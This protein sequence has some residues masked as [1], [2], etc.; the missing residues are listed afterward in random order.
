MLFRSAKTAQQLLELH[1]DFTALGEIADGM[2]ERSQWSEVLE[3]Y[4]S[5]F[6]TLV[7]QNSVTKLVGGLRKLLAAQTSDVSALELLHKVYQEAGNAGDSRDITENLA[8]VYRQSG[9]LDK[10]RELYKQLAAIEPD[11][12]D[13]VQLL[14]R[15]ESQMGLETSPDQAAA[16]PAAA[17]MSE[18][19]DFPAGDEPAPPEP[20]ALSAHEEQIVKDCITEAELYITYRQFDRALK[21]IEAGLVQ[22]PGN[23]ALTEQLLSIC[24]ASSLYARA[25][26]CCE[27]LTEAYVRLGDGERASRYGERLLGYQ[28]KSQESAAGAPQAP[29]ADESQ[30]SLR[31]VGQTEAAA[32]DYSSAT[33]EMAA[34]EQPGDQAQVREVDL[35]MEWASAATTPAATADDSL[36][37]EIEFYLQASLLPDAAAALQRLKE[38]S[39]ANPAI[40]GFEE[41]LGLNAT[42]GA[43]TP[44]P[45]AAV[46]AESAAMLDLSTSEPAVEPAALGFDPTPEPSEPEPA[47]IFDLLGAPEP[48]ATPE[49][50]APQSAEV[51]WPVAAA[52]SAPEPAP[53]GLEEAPPIPAAPAAER[54]LALDEALPALGPAAQSGEFELSLEDALGMQSAAAPA[55]GAATPPQ[56]SAP[57]AAA[58]PFASLAGDLEGAL[59]LPEMA[60]PKQAP[61]AAKSPAGPG[62]GVPPAARSK[63]ESQFDEIL[64]DFKSEMEEITSSDDMETH[65]NMGIAFKEMA[66]YDEAIGEFQKA[67]QL[68]GR[69]NDH[70]RVVQYCSLLATCFLEKGLPQ[71]AVKWYQTALD[72]PGLEPESVL[73]LLYEMG[74]ASETAGDRT[75]ALRSFLEVYARNID[76][77]DVAER[78]RSLQQP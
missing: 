6:D 48:E 54:Q 49:P 47:S 17:M 28:Q 77:R 20:P 65:F 63:A 42:P 60:A 44:S 4:R 8:H 21:T 26:E 73:A 12:P 35:S 72:S 24:D 61:A 31:S 39:P 52:T 34:E 36:V 27:A 25:A 5:A 2:I 64:A 62:A 55:A 71:L 56:A 18:I 11:N 68:A 37:E 53:L 7:S 38:S 46:E 66:L 45:E 76:Y 29:S 41:R 78:I 74:S 50:V 67:H 33:P 19:T 16:E 30:S 57:P 43:A 10:A 23:I 3:L 15:V 13:Y 14:R 51:M 69:S 22:L 1:S 58:D 40:A 75:A 70:S 32:F 9:E 59:N